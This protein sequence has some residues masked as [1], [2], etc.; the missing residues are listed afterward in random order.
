MLWRG[1]LNEAE[2]MCRQSL[3]LAK[4]NGIFQTGMVGTLYS[5]LG[6]VLCERN[7][8]DEGIRLIH[9]G[10]E[11]C[12]QGRDPVGLAA[13]PNGSVESIDASGGYCRCVKGHAGFK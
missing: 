7:E 13:V 10:I 8:F 4:E 1:R 11:L 6:T 12:Q 9:K 2:D 5:T 3:N